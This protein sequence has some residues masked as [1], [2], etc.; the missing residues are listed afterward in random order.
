MQSEPIR[1]KL[2]T[3]EDGFLV[4]P[5]CRTNKKLLPVE[6]DT[7]ARNLRIYCRV[8]KRRYKVDIAKGQCFESQ[9]R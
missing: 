4:C 1:G 8:C 2:L 7:E 6:P 9:G 3:V 5:G